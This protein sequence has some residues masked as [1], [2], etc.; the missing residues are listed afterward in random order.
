VPTWWNAGCSIRASGSKGIIVKVAFALVAH[1]NSRLVERL[2]RILVSEGHLV[3]VHYDLKS[4]LP[5]YQRLT[6]AFDGC[7]AVRFARR[8]RVEWGQ[9]PIIE[10]T[11]NCLN[12]IKTAGWEPDYVYHLS[13]TDYPIQSSAELVAFLDRNKGKEFIESVRA[14]SV[15]WVKTGPQQERYQYRYYFNWRTQRYRCEWSLGLQKMLRL[16]RKFV[17]GLTPYL[18]SQWWVLTW[19]T[20][21]KVMDLAHQPDIKRFFRRTLIPDELFFQTLVR[22]LVSESRIISHTLTLYQFSDYGWPVIY[23]SD[24]L[25]YLLRQPFFMARKLSPRQTELRDA[26]DA[27]WCSQRQR[28]RCHDAEIGIIGRE[29]EDRRLTFRNGV[30]GQPLPGHLPKRRRYGNLER[31]VIPSF[32]VIGASSAELS[33]VYNALSRH[34]DI[35]CHGQLFHPKRIEFAG[36]RNSFAGYGAKAIKLRSVSAANFVADIVRAEKHR[37]SGFLLRFGGQGGNI[38][39]V[40]FERPNVRVVIVRGDPLVSFSEEA[41]GVEPL[42]NDPFKPAA[43]AAIPRSVLV[44]HFRRFL[45]EYREYTNWL[46]SQQAKAA[47]AKPQGWVM[48][49]D[50]AVCAASYPLRPGDDLARSRI[51]ASAKITSLQ[52]QDWLAQL[53]AGLGID[54]SDATAAVGGGELFADLARLGERRRLVIDLLTASAILTASEISE[55]NNSLVPVMLEGGPKGRAAPWRVG[56]KPLPS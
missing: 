21:Q 37:L 28:P 29:Y 18:G 31:L 44:N 39:E 25:D 16:K 22:H 56:A 46:A 1:G 40:M 24:H 43:L 33:L 14:D 9:W 6:Q 7:D 38:S 53:K 13:G 8:V 52:C 20:L 26:L 30:P 11:L 47:A 5:G 36:S 48:E 34:P 42:L 51:G 19:D 3:A 17:R 35:R 54:L 4:P 45:D 2:I 55:I 49:V 50:L 27:C 10:A 41:L 12:E 23:Y 32:V 15:H